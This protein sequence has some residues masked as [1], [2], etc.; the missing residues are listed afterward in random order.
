[1][2]KMARWISVTLK[3]RLS[4]GFIIT[5]SICWSLIRQRFLRVRVIT[6][7][8]AGP[9]GMKRCLRTHLQLPTIYSWIIN[10]T[11][12]QK[13]SAGHTSL[14]LHQ[15]SGYY[16]R[17]LHCTSTILT[18]N[19]IILIPGLIFMTCTEITADSVFTT[20]QSAM[21]SK[22]ARSKTSHSVYEPARSVSTL[23]ANGVYL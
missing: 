9:A 23:F 18:F 22:S 10:I 15:M 13:R 1:M 16:Q 6:D 21:K 4:T 7:F 3:G 8:M 11:I 5:T 14:L 20:I 12:G 2:A 19:N 17:I